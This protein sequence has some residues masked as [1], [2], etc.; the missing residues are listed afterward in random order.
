MEAEALAARQ[1]G[2][3]TKQ[4]AFGAGLTPHEIRWRIRSGRWI[5]H[6]DSVYGI[7]GVP[8]TWHQAVLAAVLACGD[9]VVAAGWTAARLLGCDVPADL[10]VIE[11]TGPRPRW[12][13]LA[14]VVGHRSLHLFDEDRTVRSGI[15]CTSAARLVVDLSGRLD[16]RALGRVSDGLQRNRLVKLVDIHRCNGRLPPAPGRSPATVKR[17]LAVRWP[18]YD[19]G[20]S[21]FET[22]VLRLIAG[23]GLPLPRQ[24]F[25]V[26]LQG[27]RR[28][29]DLAYPEQKIAIEVQGPTH[30]EQGRYD[31]DRVRVNELVLLGWR[32]LEVVPAMAD[33]QIVDQI[34][35]ALAPLD[36]SVRA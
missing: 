33:A 30:R 23:A 2:L 10:D 20:A 28:Y 26:E 12:V 24:Q 9:G 3:I 8:P 18:G 1:Y 19:P 21:D 14:G 15:A 5:V 25:R 16:D 31:E 11:V 34:R 27:R 35:R 4:Q 7:A 22:K 17:M 13:R 32:P 6:R 29:I 36:R